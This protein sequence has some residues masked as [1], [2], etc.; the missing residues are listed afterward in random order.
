MTMKVIMWLVSMRMTGKP[1]KEESVWP[2]QVNL[3]KDEN[4]TDGIHAVHEQRS[5][6]THRG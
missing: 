5:G 4:E 3:D 6:P 2:R 1:K